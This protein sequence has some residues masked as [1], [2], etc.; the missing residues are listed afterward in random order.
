MPYNLPAYDNGKEEINLANDR[1]MENLKDPRF[2]YQEYPDYSSNPEDPD[3]LDLAEKLLLKGGGLATISKQ[4]TRYSEIG[5]IAE[6]LSLRCLTPDSW[7]QPITS[8]DQ[9]WVE[10]HILGGDVLELEIK[11]FEV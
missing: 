9:I 10:L 6:V 11:L 2:H 5:D 7:D 8:S 3:F 4:R 1:A